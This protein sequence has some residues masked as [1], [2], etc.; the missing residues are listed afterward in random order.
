MVN[1]AFKLRFSRFAIVLQL[2]TFVLIFILIYQLIAIWLC[3]MSLLCM[4]G[5]WFLW[6][7]QPQITH[8]EHLDGQDWSFKFSD[9]TIPIQRRKITKIIDHQSYIVLYFSKKQHKP[10]LIWWDQLPLMQWKKLKIL[11]KLI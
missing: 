3:M 8:F 6:L 2:F 10:C 7:K 1:Y 4:A 5:S 11:S 9:R